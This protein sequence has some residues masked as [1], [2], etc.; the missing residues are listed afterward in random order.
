MKKIILALLLLLIISMSAGAGILAYNN[1]STDLTD[2][3]KAYITKTL[4]DANQDLTILQ[5]SDDFDTQIKTV[6]AIQKAIFKQTPEQK[7]IRL[8]TPREPKDLYDRG[9]AL[10]GDRARF[11]HK[12]LSMLGYDVR[13]ASIYD[14]SNVDHP[15]QAIITTE[16]PKVTSHAMVE[17]K[18]SKGWMM[19][20]SVSPW[21]GLM[22]NDN[23]LSLEEWHRAQDKKI[24]SNFPWKKQEGQIYPLITKKFTYVF[25][26]YSRHGQ[27]YAPYMSV[28]D[29]SWPELFE[30]IGPTLS[31]LQG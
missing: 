29:V 18:T 11:I 4:S 28:P 2:D 23:V 17:V 14:A 3:D 6:Q 21:I 22:S 26:L 27:F 8:G 31:S 16:K 9:Y 5:Y 20:D 10:C 7:I 1:V 24:A 12:T 13:Y 19:I 25:G 15:W 30:N